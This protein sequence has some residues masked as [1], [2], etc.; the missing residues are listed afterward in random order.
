M[1]TYTYNGRQY[2]AL[3]VSELIA[4]LEK[5]DDKENKLVW[6]Y[7]YDDDSVATTVLDEPDNNRILII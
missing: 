5:I 3:N 2:K 4:M 1:A 6:V 7:S